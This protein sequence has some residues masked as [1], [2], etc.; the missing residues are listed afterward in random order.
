MAWTEIYR[1]LSS[2]TWLAVG[3]GMSWL[4]EVHC[5]VSV[6]LC[7]NNLTGSLRAVPGKIIR[8]AWSSLILGSSLF[9]KK[10]YYPITITVL[11]DSH[12]KSTSHLYQI[13]FIGVAWNR[14]KWYCHK[15]QFSWASKLE[16]VQRLDSLT[17]FLNIELPLNLNGLILKCIP[18]FHSLKV[19]EFRNNMHI[20]FMLPI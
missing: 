3:K 17:F 7:T 10:N 15:E 4:V 16:M 8:R 19:R 13:I 5:F 18:K 2:P 1:Y 11:W 14:G 6:W 9:R 20:I 12:V